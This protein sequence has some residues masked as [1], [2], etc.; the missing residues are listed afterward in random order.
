MSLDEARELLGDE[1]NAK[2]DDEQLQ[3]LIRNLEA[4]ASMT[5]KAIMDGQFKTALPKNLE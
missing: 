2:L 3:E 5:I 1:E 4:I